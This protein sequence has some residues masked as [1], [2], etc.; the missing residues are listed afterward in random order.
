MKNFTI[1]SEIGK[2]YFKSKIR[3]AFPS[4]INDKKI[5]LN[6]FKNLNDYNNFLDL[7]D[8]QLKKQVKL[9]YE[10]KNNLLILYQDIKGNKKWK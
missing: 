9:L 10:D 6:T 4:Y 3:Y 2:V 5:Y 7:I 1:E 8:N